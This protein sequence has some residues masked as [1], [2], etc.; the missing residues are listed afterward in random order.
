MK[1]T[2]LATLLLLGLFHVTNPVCA[3]GNDLLDLSLDQLLD[4]SVDTV[5]VAKGPLRRQPAT[6][7][8]LTADDLKSLGARNLMEALEFVPGTSFGVDVFG[9]ISINFRGQWAH[10]G[11]VLLLLDDLPLNDLMYGNLNLARH[12]PV[13]Q[14]DRIEVLRGAGS[15]KYGGNAQL[16]VIR[17]YS[18]RLDGKQTEIS[19]AA[20]HVKDAGAGGGATVTGAFPLTG[21]DLTL[22]GHLSRGEWSGQS[23]LDGSG[24]R[25][26]INDLSGIST[27]N[28]I[29]RLDLDNW[30]VRGFFDQ[31]T[32]E[33]PHWF[34][35]N[36]FRDGE[37]V[38]FS[39]TNLSIAYDWK[40][41][42]RFLLQPKYTHRSQK[43]WFINRDAA[44]YPAAPV[45]FFLPVKKDTMTL[46]LKTSLG[47]WNILTGVEYWQ[48]KA[49]CE[50][51]GGSGATPCTNYY[52]DAPEAKYHSTAIYGQGDWSDGPW[53]ASLGLR[54]SNHSY[55]GDSLVPRVS[56]VYAEDDWQLKAHLGQAYR[57][58]DV[59][60]IN[61]SLAATQRIQ[62][63]KATQQEIEFGWRPAADWFGTLSVFSME[64]DNSLI[65]ATTDTSY[66]NYPAVETHGIETEWRWVGPRQK[67]YF[68]YSWYQ[69][70]S[71]PNAKYGVAGQPDANVGV[72]R[73]KATLVGDYG[74][75][76]TDWTVQGSVVW[77]GELYAND[78]DGTALAVRRQS[79]QTFL[80]LSA[81]YVRKDWDAT[82]GVTDF[83]N[84]GRR[85]PQPYLDASTPYV[86]AG[87]QLWGRATLRF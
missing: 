44:V 20:D 85:Y 49:G 61:D 38:S 71:A 6:V 39:S 74:I 4:V 67:A 42:D 35:G 50:R 34:G 77:Y 26:R 73:H 81:R 78:W 46:D 2:T 65:Y 60:V 31:H 53:G 76:G 13:E 45:D 7:T 3:A 57:E 36:A 68:T 29:A 22:S 86:G 17:I 21:G 63:E 14:I 62:S 12:Y 83:N 75:A 24:Q 11:K 72:P 40:L 10:E 30:H 70:V 84:E 18:R 55:A 41:S 48:E 27:G 9:V 19:F 15:A 37:E 32:S 69:S 25:N 43:D 23:W 1:Q 82:I 8:L 33:T 5:T 59:I 16:A 64:V 47:T 56:L 54:Y 52:A 87:R 51:P 58:P 79:D 80:N 28:L 66:N